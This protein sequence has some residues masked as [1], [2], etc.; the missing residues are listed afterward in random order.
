[1]QASLKIPATLEAL[2]QITPF[3]EK[4]TA[5]APERLRTQL[6]LAIHELCVNIV[7]HAYDGVDGEIEL[8]AECDDHVLHLFTYDSGPF[9][10]R[11]TEVIAPDPLDLPESGWGMVILE[12]VMDEV[13]YERVGSINQWHLVKA[14]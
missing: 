7:Q 8:T 14:W 12:R 3:I 6:V 11:Q 10:Y 9:A 5:A 2:A 13:H 4:M 1:M